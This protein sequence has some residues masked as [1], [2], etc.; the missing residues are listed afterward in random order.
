MYSVFFGSPVHFGAAGRTSF[1]FTA[2]AKP[3]F[4]AGAGRQNIITAYHFVA[5][6]TVMNP[7]RSF[8]LPLRRILLRHFFKHKQYYTSPHEFAKPL[9]PFFPLPG[10]FLE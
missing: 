5:G 2:G 8:L 1:L 3:A 10:A 4:T 6:Y 9:C 7:V